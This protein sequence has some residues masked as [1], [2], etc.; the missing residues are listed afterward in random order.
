MILKL[1]DLQRALD[2]SLNTTHGPVGLV[3]QSPY[4]LKLTTHFIV[5]VANFYHCGSVLR[6]CFMGRRPQETH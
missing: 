2:V 5:L 3:Q 1:N 6:L 4:S